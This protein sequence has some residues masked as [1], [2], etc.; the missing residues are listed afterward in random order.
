MFGLCV[1]FTC[2]DEAAAEAYDK[3][4]A[5]TIE[6]IKTDEPEHWYTPPTRWRASLSSA[7]ST[8]CTGT[9]RRRGAQGVPAHPPLPGSAGSVPG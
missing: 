1:R 4:V 8:S 9:G 5:E 2:K 3:L 6:A 7:S